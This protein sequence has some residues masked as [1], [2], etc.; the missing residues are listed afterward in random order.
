MKIK[1][2]LCCVLASIL[3]MGCDNKKQEYEEVRA[4]IEEEKN[5]Y[6]FTSLLLETGI[7]VITDK[8]TGVQ[9]L[10]VKRGYGAGLTILVD[11]DGKPLLD[12]VVE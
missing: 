3:C 4:E 6:D 11:E 8:K 9:Y 12:E 2:L 1:I 5:K 10:F 7:T